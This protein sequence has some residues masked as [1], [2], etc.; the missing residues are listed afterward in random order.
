MSTRQR[1][2]WVREKEKEEIKMNILFLQLSYSAIIN[3]WWHYSS[4]V[5]FFTIT[6]PYNGSFW[7]FDAK[8]YQHMAFERSDTDAL[9]DTDTWE[10]RYRYE[11]LH[12]KFF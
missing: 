9:R 12:N 11:Y 6:R 4:I 8:I 1:E 10:I 3:L 7:G 2:K 5:N